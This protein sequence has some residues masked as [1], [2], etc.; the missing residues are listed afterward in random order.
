MCKPLSSV[1][2]KQVIYPPA[3]LLQL[4]DALGTDM[5]S[6][7]HGHWTHDCLYCKPFTDDNRP[8]YKVHRCV[9]NM[10]KG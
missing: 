9:M 7:Q 4:A 2:V 8:K 3:S 5:T 6:K 1:L 10:N